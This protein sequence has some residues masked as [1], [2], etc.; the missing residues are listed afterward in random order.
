MVSDPPNLN[1]TLPPSNLTAAKHDPDLFVCDIADAVLKDLMPTLEHP[2]YSLSKKPVHVVREYVRGDSWLQ[3]HPSSKGLATIYDKDILIYAVS[4]VIAAMKAGQEP[5][6]RV[7]INC[8]DFLVFTN[9]G[10]GGKDYDAMCDAIIRLDGTRIHTN[11]KTGGEEQFD[12]FGLIEGGTVRRKYGFKGRLLWVEIKLSDWVFNA[13]KAHEVLTI[14]PAYFRL[15]KPNERRLYDLARKHCGQQE[16]WSPYMKTLYE[17]SGSTGSLRLYRN[18]IKEICEN[19][20]MPDYLLL[21]NEETD[22]VIFTNKNTMPLDREKAAESAQ[23]I[24]LRLGS[25]VR[26][27]ARQLVP[28]WDIDYVQKCFAAWWYRIGKPEV[29]KPD[30]MFLKFCRTYFEKH[31]RP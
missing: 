19:T 5:K 22:Q 8:R 16:S 28:G 27:T 23:E 18:R 1:T 2:F 13:I 14:H 3:I 29:S 24:L 20:D 9:R 11:I 30:A 6:Q 17:K 4:Q 31:G 21:Y 15:P 26:E 25:D 7:R 10:T 12:T